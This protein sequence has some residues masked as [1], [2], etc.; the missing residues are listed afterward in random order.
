MIQQQPDFG[1]ALKYRRSAEVLV[2]KV[3]R[4][5]GTGKLR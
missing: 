5:P 1:G 3:V 4:W 2:C